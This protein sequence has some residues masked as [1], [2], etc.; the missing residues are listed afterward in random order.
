MTAVDDV[1][2]DQMLDR[3]SFTA[4]ELVFLEFVGRREGSPPSPMAELMGF[5]PADSEEDE[6]AAIGMRS[7]VARD[8]VT[9][10]G[11]EL[12][13]HLS[14]AAC[15]E[16]ISTV[17]RCVMVMAVSA[18]GVHPVRVIE[19]GGFRFLI[20]P[21]PPLVTDFVIIDPVVSIEALV[22]DLVESAI[23]DDAPAVEV[24]SE[25]PAALIAGA[26]DGAGDFSV[27]GLGP[28]AERTADRRRCSSIQE[29]VKLALASAPGR[30]IG[31][32]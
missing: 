9:V 8:L 32:L 22:V 1:N 26:V 17:E 31:E 23:A 18:E 25:L 7:L 14:A 4:E 28:S 29:M 20:G 2:R 30:E 10:D 16:V 12:D 3:L 24:F 13:V 19:G 27:A 15:A 5:T 11:E 21:R 6:T